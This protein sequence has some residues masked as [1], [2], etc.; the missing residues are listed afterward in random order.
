MSAIVSIQIVDDG[1]K[2]V[3]TYLRHVIPTAKVDDV[4]AAVTEMLAHR[5]TYKIGDRKA[6]PTWR[7]QKKL[8]A[9]KKDEE[10]LPGVIVDDIVETAL[11]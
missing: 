5:D 7:A 3:E 8:A 1:K 9:L 10:V 6:K 2:K 4:R 11:S